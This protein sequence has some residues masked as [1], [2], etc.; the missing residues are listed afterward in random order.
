MST[1]SSGGSWPPIIGA[2]MANGGEADTKIVGDLGKDIDLLLAADD[3]M[4]EKELIREILRIMRIEQPF[5]VQS[6]ADHSRVMTMWRT[7]RPAAWAAG[8]VIAA[9]LTLLATGR[10]TVII[11]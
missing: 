3:K 6:L 11:R 1:A 7:Y 9:F 4:S 8:I 2:N 10:A 5:L